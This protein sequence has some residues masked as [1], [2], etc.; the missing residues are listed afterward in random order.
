MV[1]DS[2]NYSGVQ[3]ANYNKNL[4]QSQNPIKYSI[5][6]NLN[7]PEKDEFSTGAK[8]AGTAVGI[9]TT[10]YL[11][12][13]GHANKWFAG[14]GTIKKAVDKPAKWLSENVAVPLKEKFGAN[15]NEVELKGASDKIGNKLQ[16]VTD[17]YTA[18]ETK[19]GELFNKA[20]PE[21]QNLLKS[22]QDTELV[23][24][25]Q[26]TLVKTAAQNVIEKQNALNA[27]K[28]NSKKD[29]KDA[30]ELSL[31]EDELRFAQAELRQAHFLRNEWNIH[32][33][34]VEEQLAK[35]DDAAS[36]VKSSDLLKASK[37]KSKLYNQKSALEEKKD[38]IEAKLAGLNKS[39]TVVN[40]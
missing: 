13:H 28:A 1:V 14:E 18:A 33:K 39:I 21:Q 29:A 10:G 38:A 11:L 40:K 3:E 20:T 22:L 4:F 34:H 7:E 30:V 8:A 31:K 25:N 5:K 26:E 36:Q 17:K 15:L 35:A 2:V 23:V 6:N 19:L 24:N 9:L 37:E 27:L 32:L 16:S 12:A